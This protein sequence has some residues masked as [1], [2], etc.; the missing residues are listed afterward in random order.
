MH[1]RIAP[2]GPAPRV[3]TMRALQRLFNRSHWVLPLAALAAAVVLS[4][5]CGEDA[6]LVEP[7]GAYQDATVPRLD[8]ALVLYPD[9]TALDGGASDG[10]TEGGPTDGASLGCKVVI[11]SPPIA[12]DNTHVPIDTVVNY[13]TNP[14][15]SGQHYPIWASFRE[16]VTPVDRR[17][18]VHDL[19]HGAVVVTYRCASRDGCPE[20]ADALRAVIDA[21][22]ADPLCAALGEGVKHRYVLT[23]DPLIP[24]PVAASAWGWTYTADCVDPASLGEFLRVHYAQAPENFCNDG[25]REF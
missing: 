6:S 17:Y 9:A 18:Y 4:P 2:G 8:G 22:P 19:E 7:R 23:P 24:T 20:L 21:Q 13:A 12:N 10:S 16:F 15:S 3:P 14:P 25:Q 11:E 1:L 5:A